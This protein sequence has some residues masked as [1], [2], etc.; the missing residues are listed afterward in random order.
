LEMITSGEYVFFD[1]TNASYKKYPVMYSITV[2][3]T[4]LLYRGWVKTQ[5]RAREW[6]PKVTEQPDDPKCFS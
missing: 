1:M 5:K 2:A 3:I 4:G 6:K